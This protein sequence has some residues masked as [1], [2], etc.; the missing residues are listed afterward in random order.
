MISS[1]QDLEQNFIFTPPGLG[2]I[3][4]QKLS[5]SGFLVAQCS[6]PRITAVGPVFMD[7]GKGRQKTQISN[8]CRS[9][10]AQHKPSVMPIEMVSLFSVFDKTC[11]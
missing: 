5:R 8:K 11:F 9:N 10:Q 3:R 2:P 4:T 7:V 1:V 6:L